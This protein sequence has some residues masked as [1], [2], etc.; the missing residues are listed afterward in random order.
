MDFKEREEM[1]A[2]GY[3]YNPDAKWDWYQ[4]GEDGEVYL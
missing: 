1:G 4:L 2:Y 3:W